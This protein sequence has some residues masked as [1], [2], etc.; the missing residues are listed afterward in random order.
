MYYILC[1]WKQMNMNQEDDNLYL[2]GNKDLKNK[3]K[4]YIQEIHSIDICSDFGE[5]ELTLAQ[6]IPF[7]IK[8]LYLCAL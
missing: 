4:K 3:L 7:A 2:Y 6:N 1:V 8:T 5:N